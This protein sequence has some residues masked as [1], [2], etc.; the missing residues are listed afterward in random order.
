M[1]GLLEED[2]RGLLPKNFYAPSVLNVPQHLKYY[3]KHEYACIIRY[4]RR[5]APVRV[6]TEKFKSL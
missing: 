1:A 3:L 6:R 4:K 2:K 5:G